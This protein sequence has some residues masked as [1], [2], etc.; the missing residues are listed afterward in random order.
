MRLLTVIMSFAVMQAS[1]SPAS[2]I[3]SYLEQLA[4][5]D[6]FSGAVA[7][8]VD[9][10]LILS[11]GYGLANREHRAANTPET[12][13]RIASLT[14]A[15]TAAA[16]LLLEDRGKLGTADPVGKHWP[17]APEAWR[18]LTIHQ[19]LNH[20]SGLTHPW[21]DNGFEDQMM[22]PRSMDEVLRAYEDEP[23]RHAPG[24]E[25]SYSGVGYFV[26]A[27]IVEE[28]SGQAYHEFLRGSILEPL[29]M[30]STDGDRPEPVVMNRAA[31]YEVV[32]GTLRNA[33]PIYM[34]ILTGGGD[35]H[36]TLVDMQHWHAALAAGELLSA[37]AYERM[38]T[39]GL[40]DYGYGW[41]ILEHGDLTM[42][43]HTGGLPGF[44][45][46][47]VHFPGRNTGIVV[48]SNRGNTN[49]D[50]TVNYLIDRVVETF[51]D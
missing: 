16:I 18:D 47:M 31:G 3:D 14:K 35:L 17:A 6:E 46:L 24:T 32:D 38:W 42:A 37:G 43:L 27:R 1:A 26:L 20:T 22:I 50:G 10:D 34:P 33:A 36:S 12:V 28:A 5:R 9:G 41:R 51:A 30:D 15:F 44:A 21:S 49:R 23:L 25:F 45:A 29:G 7:V 8:I 11:K 40:N 4:G 2:D 19:L 48:L 13:F 39:P